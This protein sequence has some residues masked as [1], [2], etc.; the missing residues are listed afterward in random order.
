MKL[1]FWPG[2]KSDAALPPVKDLLPMVITNVYE[3]SAAFF[4]H[5]ETQ[6]ADVLL[7]PH[8]TWAPNED[9]YRFSC[10]LSHWN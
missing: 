1:G 7:F 5:T 8:T 2:S 10:S 3:F 4:L 9:L 6:E